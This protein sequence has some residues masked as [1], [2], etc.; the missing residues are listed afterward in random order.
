MTS[1][2]T[3]IKDDMKAAMKAGAK[4]ELEVLRTILSDLKNAAIA[5][6]GERSGLDDELVL[7]VLRKGVKTRSESADMYKDAG[8]DDLEGKERFQIGVLERYLPAA[9]SEAELEAL[10][11][12]VIGDLGASTKKEMGAVMKEVM[13]RSGGR[14]D[15]K[16]VS[17]L[18]GRKLS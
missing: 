16:A 8:R 5:S 10:V 14:A 9:L 17:G 1:L 7:K 11:D 4:D 6:G 3:R 12:G 13:A 15:G 2:E 18:V